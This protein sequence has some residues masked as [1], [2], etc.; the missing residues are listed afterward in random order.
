[1]TPNR[2]DLLGALGATCLASGLSPG[3]ALA[4]E[5][6]QA[7]HEAARKEGKVV[8]WGSP[9][10]RT[11][12]LLIDA[13]KRRFPG[14]DVEVFKIQSAAAIERIIAGAQ[15]GR[16]E[17]DV[18][19]SILGYL[20]LLFD[21]GLAVSH[22]WTENFGIDPTRVLFDG[23]AL[24]LWHLDSPVAVN[25]GVVKAGEVGSWADLLEPKWRGKLLVEARGFAF[26]ILA[27]KWGEQQTFDYLG[28]ILAQKPIITKGG[29]ATIEAL[30]AGQGSL[31]IGAYAGTVEQFRRD[32]APVDWLRFGPVPAA[33]AVLLQLSNAPHPN[34]ARLW[35]Y[36]MMSREAHDANYEGLGLDIVF[37]R[38]VG[39]LG[40]KYVAANLEV[41][42]ETT[43]VARMQALVTRA[44]TMISAFQ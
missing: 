16:A 1:M 22:P 44:N 19:D 10:S 32:G 17:A 42:P 7:L 43:D 8:Y 40:K 25:T 13:F 9:D 41:V 5:R 26:A 30:S 4:Q 20:P 39:E 31:A 23:K 35:S 15:S 18:V 38:D 14:V 3:R 37:G 27:L 21:R 12:R 29:T 28:K 2:R 6:L 36:F 24:T 33:Y 34:A 11:A